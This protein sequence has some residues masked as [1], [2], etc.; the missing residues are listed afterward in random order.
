MEKG[1]KSYGALHDRVKSELKPTRFRNKNSTIIDLEKDP[2]T[3]ADFIELSKKIRTIHA[4][5]Y[6]WEATEKVTDNV[7]DSYVDYVEQDSTATDISK[8]RILV[9][10]ITDILDLCQQ[11]SEFDPLKDVEEIV[12]RQTEILREIR[13]QE[14]LED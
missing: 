8:T 5:G 12:D 2:L 1:I 10:T 13:N 11:N 6:Q 7:L 9:K 4:I 14:E 3:R